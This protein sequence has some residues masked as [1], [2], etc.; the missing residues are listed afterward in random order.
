MVAIR[1]GEPVRKSVGRPKGLA[2]RTDEQARRR[3][4][5]LGL[6]PL[7]GQWRGRN[8]PCRGEGQSQP[9]AQ[10]KPVEDPRTA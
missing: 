1:T 10:A 2:E 8:Q 6:W 5:C 9:E 3:A 4:G 7:G